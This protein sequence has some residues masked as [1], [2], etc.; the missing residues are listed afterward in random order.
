[1]RV[2]TIVRFNLGC[3]SLS[4]Q[5][6]A[7]GSFQAVTTGASGVLLLGA[8]YWKLRVLSPEL[9]FEKETDVAVLFDFDFQFE[10]KRQKNTLVFHVQEV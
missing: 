6:D 3:P 4:L 10:T 7:S 2:R 9:A 8:S 1:M 5:I